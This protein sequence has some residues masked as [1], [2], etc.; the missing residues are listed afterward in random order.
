MVAVG[1]LQLLGAEGLVQQLAA[2]GYTVERR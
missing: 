1:T 2:S